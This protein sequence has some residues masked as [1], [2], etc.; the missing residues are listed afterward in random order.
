[1]TRGYTR[2]AMA[3]VRDQA[4]RRVDLERRLKPKRTTK[5]FPASLLAGTSIS[6]DV[7]PKMYIQRLDLGPATRR[8][9]WCRFIYLPL[10]R[11]AEAGRRGVMGSK[12]CHRQALH[13][14]F[15]VWELAKHSHL[16]GRERSFFRL[17]GRA[18]NSQGSD[19]DQ[20]C[21]ADTFRHFH[22]ARYRRRSLNVGSFQFCQMSPMPNG[23]PFFIAIA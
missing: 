2:A 15:L 14:P 18:Y 3:L 19:H 6:K 12:K 8:S 23:C 13:F 7:Y 16:G 21:T 10:S 4:A 9:K 11:L 1:M 17:S 5:N 22:T 20:D